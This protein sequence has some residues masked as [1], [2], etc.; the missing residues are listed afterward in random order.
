MS[1]G[2][3]NEGVSTLPNVTARRAQYLTEAGID[4]VG[5][6]V[7]KYNESDSTEG[8]TKWLESIGIERSGPILNA[9]RGICSSTSDREGK[10]STVPPEPEQPTTTTISSTN[11]KEHRDSNIPVEKPLDLYMVKKGGRIKTAKDRHFECLKDKIVY[12][13]VLTGEV[14]GTIPLDQISEI[15]GYDE[16]NAWFSLITPDTHH[17]SYELCAQSKQDYETFVQ[18]LRERGGVGTTDWKDSGS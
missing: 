5:K 7:A 16:S 18:Y 13:D 12:R 4:T 17:G 11:T 3:H 15:T 6:L 10:E 1:T 2:L 9:V 14:K 8:F